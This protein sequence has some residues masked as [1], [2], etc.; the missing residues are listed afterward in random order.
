V[1]LTAF[2]EEYYSVPQVYQLRP[3]PPKEMALDCIGATGIKARFYPGVILKVEGLVPGSP[4]DG[5]FHV[6]QIIAGVNG[7]AFQG[8][9]PIVALGQA[10]TAAEASDGRLVFDVQDDISSLPKQVLVNVPILG[11]YTDTWPLSC[12]KSQKIIK[13]AAEYYAGDPT[14][15]EKYFNDKS[16]NGGMPSALACLFLLSTGDDQYLPVVKEY[17]DGFPEDLSKIGDH[18][19]N[20]GYNGIACAEYYL[21]TG[22]KEVLPILQ[23][24]CDNAAERQYFG[25]GWQ[26][27]GRSIS[28]RYVAGGLMNPAGAQVLTTLLLGKVCG[29]DVDDDTLL[30]ALRYWYR[31]VGHGTVPY[32]DHRSEGGLGSN[33]KD[34][35]A[36]AAMRIASQAATETSVYEQ[37]MKHLSM[38]TLT[39]YPSLIR[40]HADEGRGD[41]IWRGIASAYMLDYDSDAYHAIMQDLRWWYDLSRRPSGALG[42]ATNQRFDD[43]GS[44]AGVALA[45]TAPLKTLQITGA[46]RSQYA[47]DFTLPEQIWGNAADRV[48]LSIEHVDGFNTYGEEEPMHTSFFRYGSAYSK[49]DALADVSRDNMLKHVHHKRYMIRSQAAKALRV[50]GAFD[51]LE[52]LLLAEDPRVRRAALDGMMDYRYWFHIGK[53]PM[54]AEQFTPGMIQAVQGMLGNEQESWYVVDGALSVMSLMAPSIITQNVDLVIPWARHTEWWIR[55]SAFVALASAATDTNATDKVLPVLLD[56]MLAETHTMPRNGMVQGLDRLLKRFSPSSPQ[57]QAIL[58]A[59]LEA[60]S[61][62]QIISGPRAGEGEWDVKKSSEAILQ[63]TPARALKV[64]QVASRRM[65]EF[66]TGWM[67]DL[68][69]KL[70]DAQEK[71]SGKDKEALREVLCGSYRDELIERLRENQSNLALLDAIVSLNAL[72]GLEVGWHELGNPSYTNRMWR[73]ISVDPK[74]E[75]VLHSREKKRFRTITLPEGLQTWSESSFDDSTW[76]TGQAPIG[77]GEFRR[78][79]DMFANQ[80][81]WGSGEFLLAR[82]AFELDTLDYDIYRICILA[83]QGFDVFLNGKKV[84]TYIWWRND[85]HYRKIVLDAR[86]VEAL[87]TGIN[88]LA[89][90]AGSD[91]IKDVHVGQFDIY[92]EALRKSELLGEE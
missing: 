70:L 29:V 1:V 49:P 24:Y 15:R 78:G 76:Q 22:D 31:F 86:D 72:K 58:S 18:T 88:T 89:V 23:Y 37:A 5:K 80:S 30:G 75:D 66:S 25:S 48:F 83:N 27:W 17:F 65:N 51:V 67:V 10:L 68:T 9:N 33:G 81:D 50:T 14:F 47:V 34:G 85:P 6:G 2:A 73:Y 87:K 79:R 7:V 55:Q 16:E 13:M 53:N 11:A 63:A 59:H 35:M 71:V 84:E 64:A 62:R 44:G 28:P 32:G 20:N 26:H 74:G 46:P 61:S 45:Y 39:S 57:G 82:T 42:M 21:R 77:V 69:Q 4:A 36:A 38:A 40:G 92:I 3:A 54:Q 60:I 8:I 52:R 41:G 91:F 19:W 43:E 90:R 56:M 12:E